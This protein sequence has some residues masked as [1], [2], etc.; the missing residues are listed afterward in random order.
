MEPLAPGL[1]RAGAAEGHWEG[2]AELVG[3]EWAV[4]VGVVKRLSGCG[5]APPGR[6]EA[7]AGGEDGSQTLAGL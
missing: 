1:G 3:E 5:G 6:G 4:L 7:G 2:G